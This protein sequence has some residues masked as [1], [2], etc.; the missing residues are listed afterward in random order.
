M[1]QV[2]LIFFFV[3][4]MLLKNVLITSVS[5]LTTTIII[6]N[7]IWPLFDCLGLKIKAF[8]SFL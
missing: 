5:T 1:L 3:A 6:D 7:Y 4:V 8:E 2:F